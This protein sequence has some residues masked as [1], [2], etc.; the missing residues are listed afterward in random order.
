M[1]CRHAILPL[2]GG[3]GVHV[4][5]RVAHPL[6]LK[7]IGQRR[8]FCSGGSAIRGE[9]GLG[10]GTGRRDRRRR[11]SHP[12][13]RDGCRSHRYGKLGSGLCVLETG[14]WRHDW[15]EGRGGGGRIEGRYGIDGI[16]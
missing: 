8:G 13:L 4:K 9:L 3:F 16:G 10:W 6:V 7:S 1:G 15:G 2:Q 5:G 11:G 14:R 12:F